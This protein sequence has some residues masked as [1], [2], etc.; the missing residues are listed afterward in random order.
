[1][2]ERSKRRAVSLAVALTVA[3]SFGCGGSQGEAIGV[4][5]AS[6]S[7]NDFDADQGPGS[8]PG[9][10]ASV[11]TT[12]VAASTTPPTPTASSL[13]P[14]QASSTATSLVVTSGP[15]STQKPPADSLVGG[16]EEWFTSPSGNIACH[17]V[18]D[19][20]T[21]C[22]IGEKDW[23]IERPP[24]SFCEIADF[25]NA[26]E[27]GPDGPFWPCYTD[28]RW[29]FAAGPLAYGS[30]LTVGSVTCRSERTG[31]TCV[32]PE[33]SGFFISRAEGTMF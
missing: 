32:G 4:V 2:P 18:A 6:V 27:L 28:S 29:D 26:I 30:S 11:P 25:G 33:G 16:S 14:E 15:L 12:V 9:E 22:W 19:E 5:E 24:G 17:L 13:E 23:E 7:A 1:M 8:G 20:S 3:S 10:S 21:S 31:V